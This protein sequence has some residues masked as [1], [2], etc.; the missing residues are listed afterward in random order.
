VEEMDWGGKL[1]GKGWVWR[2]VCR[3]EMAL[4]MEIS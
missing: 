3:R 4:V 1:V 2:M